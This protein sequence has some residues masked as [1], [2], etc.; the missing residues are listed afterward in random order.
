MATLPQWFPPDPS[1]PPFYPPQIPCHSWQPRYWPPNWARAQAD[2]PLP[3][4]WT[5]WVPWRL[6]HPLLMIRKMSVSQNP[7]LLVIIREMT[8]VTDWTSKTSS[9]SLMTL[10]LKYEEDEEVTQVLITLKKQWPTYYSSDSTLH[11]FPL[12][13]RILV[14]FWEESCLSLGIKSFLIGV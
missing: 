11:A 5:S 12:F 13:P 3:F 1:I 10:R 14:L 2:V 8:T 6:S 9:W 7:A 4:P